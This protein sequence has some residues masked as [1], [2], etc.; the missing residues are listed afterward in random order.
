[1]DET[2]QPDSGLLETVRRLFQTLHDV[3]VNRIELFLIE[4]KEERVRLFDALLLAATA[5]VGAVMML[6][7][8]TLTV[9]V[10]FWDTYRW[11]VLV[12]LTV[13]YAVGAAVAFIK[14]RSRLQHW[15]AYA[16]SLDEI[17]K[18]CACFKKPN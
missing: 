2:S 11:L 18:D 17:K 6:V 16:A 1:M 8:I 14:L 12:L 9:L 3:A 4:L 5:I 7:M 10:V 13:A 15:Q